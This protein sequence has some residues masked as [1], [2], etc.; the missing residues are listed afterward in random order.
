MPRS[1]SK[2]Q[3]LSHLKIGTNWGKACNVVQEVA[4]KHLSVESWNAYITR[5][6]KD[7]AECNGSDF[8][9]MNGHYWDWKQFDSCAAEIVNTFL[10]YFGDTDLEI[11]AQHM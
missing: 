2:A 5:V 7:M 3:I 10:D 6:T 11:I 8:L 1:E 9:F 4:E